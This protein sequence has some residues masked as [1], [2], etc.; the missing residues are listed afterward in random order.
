V[1]AEAATQPDAFHERSARSL[2]RVGSRLMAWNKDGRHDAALQRL[3]AQLD[4]V[5]GKLAPG[6]VQRGTCATVLKPGR[7]DKIA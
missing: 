1:F 4:A 6:D 5:C 3:R 7:G 2:Q